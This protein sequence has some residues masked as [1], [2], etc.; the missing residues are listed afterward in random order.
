MKYKLGNGERVSF[1]FDSWSPLGPLFKLIGEDGPRDFRI[2]LHESVAE[3]CSQNQWLL[4]APRS[5]NALA[6][7]HHLA[8]I[9]L[10]LTGAEDLVCWEIEGKIHHY[11]PT[12][13]TW[14]FLRPKQ[15]TKDWAA[16]VWFK[17]AIPKNAFNIWVTTLDRL[18]TRA[19]LA[20]WGIQTSPNCC[21][22]NDYEETRE[23]IFFSGAG[24][25]ARFGT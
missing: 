13:Q 3:S 17:G 16:S 14:N 24:L 5:V 25:V 6:V 19:R 15:S 2:P 10:P 20:S 22:C 18:P 9:S 23:T 8:A 21:F 1:W 7:H 4:A 12:A 11:Y